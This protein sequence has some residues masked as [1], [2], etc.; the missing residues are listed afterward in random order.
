MRA[1]GVLLAGPEF[2]CYIRSDIGAE[3]DASGRQSRADTGGAGGLPEARDHSGSH[4]SGDAPGGDRLTFLVIG[5]GH[6]ER[7][8]DGVLEARPL[9]LQ[10][11]PLVVQVLVMQGSDAEFDGA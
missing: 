8:L 6:D 10:V 7:T 4:I 11:R 2:A 1:S 5:S 3:A 9:A